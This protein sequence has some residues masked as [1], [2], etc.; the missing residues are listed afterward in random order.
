MTY[1]LMS[2]AITR[3]HV[4]PFWSHQK[5]LLI[6][7]VIYDHPKIWM[8]PLLYFLILSIILPTISIYFIFLN[9]K[10][11]IWR[12][13]ILSEGWSSN[14]RR[15]PHTTNTNAR[16]HQM[17]CALC[18]AYKLRARLRERFFSPD[19]CAAGRHTN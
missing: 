14:R 12:P 7:I 18:A 4:I 5:D 3:L 19:T 10:A 11:A 8:W 13:T 9:E 17:H 2:L 16:Q 15:S 1:V 6:K